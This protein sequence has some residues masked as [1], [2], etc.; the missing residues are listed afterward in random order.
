MNDVSIG[1]YGHEPATLVHVKRE[2]DSHRRLGSITLDRLDDLVDIPL[3]NAECMDFEDP[4]IQ[5]Q[6]IAYRAR[7]RNKPEDRVDIV[8]VLPSVDTWSMVLMAPS[9]DGTDLSEAIYRLIEF[10][11]REQRQGILEA[12]TWGYCDNTGL[13]NGDY[14]EVRVAGLD[15]SVLEAHL[16]R[17]SDANMGNPSVVTTT[18]DALALAMQEKAYVVI[19]SVVVYREG[20]KF[21]AMVVEDRGCFPISEPVTNPCDLRT[22]VMGLI[23]SYRESR[24]YKRDPTTVYTIGVPDDLG[25]ELKQGRLEVKR[26]PIRMHNFRTE[27]E[28]IAYSAA[29]IGLSGS[30]INLLNRKKP[31]DEAVLQSG[32]FKF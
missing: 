25:V 4:E 22:S 21:S 16:N 27:A 5:K 1:I 6:F 20:D 14:S 15:R 10:E 23:K 2:G 8:S 18:H 30:G 19:P 24:N 11:F 17:L 29:V 3:P 31:E 26:L 7:G 13:G 32:L 12:D 9:T 28:F